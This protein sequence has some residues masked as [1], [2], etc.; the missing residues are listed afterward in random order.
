LEFDS[1]SLLSLRDLCSYP[2]LTKENVKAFFP[3]RMVAD[4]LSWKA[5]YGV[6]TSGTYDRVMVFQDEQKRNWDRAADLVLELKGNRYRPGNRTVSMPPDACAEICGAEHG[7]DNS[8]IRTAFGQLFRAHPAE[9]TEMKRQFR[10]R[11]LRDYLW[12]MHVL[13]SLSRSGTAPSDRELDEHLDTIKKWRPAVLKGLPISIYVLARQ[14][15]K[16]NRSVPGLKA[17]RPVGGK[18]SRIMATVVEQAFG[19]PIRENYGTREL[20]T[21]GFDCSVNSQQH[22]L[23][24]LFVLEFLRNDKPVEAGELGEIVVTDLRNHATPLIRYRVGDVGRYF[25]GPCKCGF[26]GLLFSV[27]GRLEETI[28]TR[29]G[30]AVTGTQLIDSLLAWDEIAFVKVA[31]TAETTFLVDIVPSTPGSQVP[32]DAELAQTLGDLLK[33]SVSVKKRVTRCIVPEAS[34]K[35]QLVVSTTFQRLRETKRAN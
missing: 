18:F 8:R 19:A 30:R 6:S 27:D 34:G 1:A 3:D 23:S 13:P 24:E 28:V 31:Q 10:R 32:T 15:K 7:R 16:R 22:L 2:V 14:A 26:E 25:K 9:R 5:L 12:R 29:E 11:V 17:V 21:I 33:Q 4:D 20:G 35:Y